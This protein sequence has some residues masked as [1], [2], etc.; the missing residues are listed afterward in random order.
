MCPQFPNISISPISDQDV[1]VLMF[2]IM[3]DI[4]TPK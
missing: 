2:L 3:R 1:Q 4:D